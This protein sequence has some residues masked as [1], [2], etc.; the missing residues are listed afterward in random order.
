MVYIGGDTLI[1]SCREG[2]TIYFD[3]NYET[4]TKYQPYSSYGRPYVC[5]DCSKRLVVFLQG[6]YVQFNVSET[7][8]IRLELLGDNF[9]SGECFG[10]SS[11]FHFVYIDQQE[12]TFILDLTTFN[13]TQL[14]TKPCFTI[15]NNLKCA[16]VQVLDNQYLVVRQWENHENLIGPNNS[17]AQQTTV[18]DAQDSFQVV[19]TISETNRSTSL[20]SIIASNLKSCPS[21]VPIVPTTEMTM[22][23][24]ASRS[25]TPTEI[26]ETSEDRISTNLATTSFTDSNEATLILVIAIGVTGLV[27]I[28]LLFTVTILIIIII[29][30][31]RHTE[32]KSNSR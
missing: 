1:G 18:F 2:A 7:K 11:G 20:I 28:V 29:I 25:T 26:I 24:T 16:Q 19:T 5:P 27:L 17:T 30:F 12:G 13:F 9:V 15:D 23:T 4:W 21:T 3:L 32:N 10:N 31:V 14:S 6:G 8:M 22:A